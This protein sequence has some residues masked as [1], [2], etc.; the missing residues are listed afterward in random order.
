LTRPITNNVLKVCKY[1]LNNGVGL[2][3][4][5]VASIKDITIN[6]EYLFSFF[7]TE[8][9]KKYLKSKFSE[10]L[11][12][13][14]SPKDLELAPIPLPPLSIQAKIVEKIE[15]LLSELDRGKAQLLT[16]QAQLKTYRQAVL[17]YAFEGK[18]TGENVKEGELPKGW[19][20]VKIGDI[21]DVGTGITP[22][23][24]NKTF[25]EG[26]TIP[27]I[28]SG[29]LND[30]KVYK[31][32][33]F[34]TQKALNETNLKIYPKHT[35][36]VALYGEGKTRG[37]CSEL[38]F[39]ST[40]NQAIA[41]IKLKIE[42]SE[43]RNFLKMFLLKKYDDLRTLASGGVQPNLNLS[44]IKNTELPFPPLSIQAQIVSEIESR[45]SV[46]DKLEETIKASLLQSES[47]R[48]S[49]LKRAFEGKLV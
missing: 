27:W 2:L 40:T 46:C 35:L 24:T 30:E 28:T 23:R 17:K 22:L 19:K 47:L 7:Q 1:P 26:G 49:V 45:L 48:Q 38:F 21:A 43:S 10:T 29:A 42:F 34:I 25:W 13:N 4:Q 14:L 9:F 41:A 12:P 32:K 20:W 5:R 31:A 36:L 44:L 39:E 11:Q 6:K 18:L 3:N 37:K 15:T 33:E 16:A 8:E